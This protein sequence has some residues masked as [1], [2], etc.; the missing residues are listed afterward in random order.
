MLELVIFGMI[1]ALALMVG[2]KV[3]AVSNVAMGIITVMQFACIG[4]FILALAAAIIGPVL[5]LV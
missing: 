5:M 2:C 4:A 1:V 3:K